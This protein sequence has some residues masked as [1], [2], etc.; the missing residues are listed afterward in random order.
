MRKSGAILR[1]VGVLDPQTFAAR[2]ADFLRSIYPQKTAQC[3][4]ADT[5]LSPKTVAKWLEGAASPKGN[6]YHS[7]IGAYGPE[8]F[9]FVDPEG[10]PESL[11]EAARQCAQ[12]RL[13]RQRD[14][15]ERSIADL[16]SGR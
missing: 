10:S 5:D 1:R 15:L 6:A 14:A 9:V 3:V 11:R 12:A 8:I 16:W 7:L 13:E 4:A 2:I